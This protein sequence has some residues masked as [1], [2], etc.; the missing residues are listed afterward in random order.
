MRF[1][2]YWIEQMREDPAER[3][4]RTREHLNMVRTEHKQTKP[5]DVI[6]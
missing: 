4:R 6:K 1:I 5:N 3:E 2:R